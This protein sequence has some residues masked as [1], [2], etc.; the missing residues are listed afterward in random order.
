MYFGYLLHPPP[1]LRELARPAEWGF[2]YMFITGQ[3]KKMRFIVLQCYD[4]YLT[5]LQINE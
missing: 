3:K 2:V 1:P 4:S 5:L